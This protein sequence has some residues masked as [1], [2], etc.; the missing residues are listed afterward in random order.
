M[1]RTQHNVPLRYEHKLAL[2]FGAVVLVLMLLATGAAFLLLQRAQEREEDRLCETITAIVSESISRVSFSG[3]HHARLM[4][5][6]ILTRAPQLVSISIETDKGEVLAHSSPQY[7]DSK[8]DPDALA[9]TKRSLETGK[10]VLVERFWGKLVVKEVVV[11]YRGGY[12]NQVMG[13]VRVGVGL[14]VPTGHVRDHGQAS[15]TY[16]GPDRSGHGRRFLSQQAVRTRHHQPGQPVARHPGQRPAGN[17]LMR[18]QGT[19]A[20]LQRCFPRPYEDLRH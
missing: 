3:K 16:R 1:P 18:Q 5:Q 17:L 7:N 20:G 8:V 19:P 14:G 6:E 4:A 2:S 15:D 13:V 9:L 10:P 12:D 11:P